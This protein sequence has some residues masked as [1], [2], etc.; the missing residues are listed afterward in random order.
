[1]RGF[2]AL[3]AFAASSAAAEPWPYMKRENSN[4]LPLLVETRD[5]PVDTATVRETAE[6][7]L[8][9]FQIT[10]IDPS[11][12]EVPQAPPWL[13]VNVACLGGGVAFRTDVDFVGQQGADLVRWSLNS[14]SGLGV[15]DDGDGAYILEEIEQRVEA[16][17]ADY[18]SANAEPDSP[19]ETPSR[20]NR[21][22]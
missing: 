4:E 19:P 16:A 8:T 10:P 3:A 13:S 14:Y 20:R 7:V 22:R 1:M 9:R 17:V 15:A 12:I 21:G 5:C 6:S 18:V 2:I 11:K